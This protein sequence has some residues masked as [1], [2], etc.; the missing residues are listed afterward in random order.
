MTKPIKSFLL[1]TLRNRRGIKLLRASFT[2]I[3]KLGMKVES[4]FSS[5]NWSNAEL[6]RF[7]HL[8]VGDVV[9]VSG[10]L[11]NDRSGQG[12][13]YADYFPNHK[14]YTITNYPGTRGLVENPQSIP[15][16][17]EKELPLDMRGRFDVVF[18]HTTLEHILDAGAAI[19]SLAGLSRDV[20]IIVV[21]FIQPQH[22][23]QG[24]YGDYWRF[25][26]M[27]LDR[28][29]AEEGFTSLYV[30]A[31]EQNWFP[32]YIF[33]IAS[34]HPEKWRSRFPPNS[35][36]LLDRKLCEDYFEW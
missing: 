11:D 19:D 32:V 23:E 24:S 33:Y 1:A 3:Q 12:K 7:G 30:S 35:T 26:P 16:D 22:Y 4:G 29:F 28:L 17:L 6:A 14:S 15:L 36:E 5:R 2:A 20:V 34:R 8:F 10:W 27:A 18:N 25:T 21:P 13:K 9:N 31:N